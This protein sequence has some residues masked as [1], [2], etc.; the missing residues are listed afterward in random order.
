MNNKNVTSTKNEPDMSFYTALTDIYNAAKKLKSKEI[1]QTE[2]LPKQNQMQRITKKTESSDDFKFP[3]YTGVVFRPKRDLSRNKSKDRSSLRADFKPETESVSNYFEEINIRIEKSTMSTVEQS[4]FEQDLSGSSPNSISSSISS[5][6]SSRIS[7]SDENNSEISERL[8]KLALKYFGSDNNNIKTSNRNRSI[9][10]I[11]TEEDSE[12]STELEQN[13][14]NLAVKCLL[15]RSASFLRANIKPTEQMS[16]SQTTSVKHRS[17]PTFRS[18][19]NT[20]SQLNFL[21]AKSASFK[22]EKNLSI[23]QQPDLSKAKP[24]KVI[25]KKPNPDPSNIQTQRTKNKVT[26][27]LPV[28]QVSFSKHRSASNFLRSYHLARSS[29]YKSLP[30]EQQRMSSYYGGA[31]DGYA[32]SFNKQ[33]A[34]K[35]YSGM[36]DYNVMYGQQM[37]D[38]TETQQTDGYGYSQ[39]YGYSNMNGY[40]MPVVNY[41]MY[42]Y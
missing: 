31:S 23:S 8:N 37:V 3:V 34:K 15:E 12:R 1:T 32:D 13:I 33:S 41:S 5:S 30:K 26:F 6:S 11:D 40:R 19:E 18:S 35:R 14:K 25:L 21:K 4:T 20:S 7:I 27:K 38:G 28:E 17:M 24:N 42:G 29:A 39:M 16:K 36:L 2:E 10:L 22:T 9:V